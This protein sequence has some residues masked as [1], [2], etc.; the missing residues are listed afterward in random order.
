MDEFDL[1]RLD[2]HD[3]EVLCK[4]LFEDILGVPLEVFAQGRDGGVDLRHVAED[5]NTTV[6]QCKHWMRSGRGK[7]LSHM[8]N[9]ELPKIV[10]LSPDRY[11][12]A[13]SV[14]LTVAAKDTL[15]TDLAPYVRSTGDIYGIEQLV[16]ELR[17]RP[18]IVRRHYKLWLS[19][20]AVL[21]GV[22][23]QDV[24][25]RSA[26]LVEEV[27]D[28]VPT[29]VATSAFD[30]AREILAANSVCL[31]VGIP[32]IGK[33][34][35][36]R[37]LVKM[38]LDQG[39]QPI[40]LSDGLDE[41]DDMWLPDVPQ[42]FYYDD[43]LGRVALEPKLGKN[44]DGR[45]L[46][47][48]RRIRRTRGKR[49]ILTTREYILAQGRQRYGRLNDGDLDLSTCTI[50][51]EGFTAEVRAHIL[52]NHVRHSGIPITEKQRF[53]SSE[54]WSEIVRHPNFNPRLIT[55]TLR[56]ASR[57]NRTS[58]NVA[59]ELIRNLRN[60]EEIW[61]HVITEELDDAAVQLLEVMF[62]FG[63]ETRMDEVRRAWGRY[64]STLGE[65]DDQRLFLRALKTLN[66]S[67]ITIRRYDSPGAVED[68]RSDLV[69]S[70][71]RELD[72]H[73]PSIRDHLAVRAA[74]GLMSLSPLIESIEYREQILHLA[75]LADGHP[76]PGMAARFREHAPAATRAAI[77][78]YQD[79]A[80]SPS[81]EDESWA[82]NLEDTLMIADAF[83]S[84]ELAAFVVKRLDE[85]QSELWGSHAT[86]LV[87]LAE[88]VEESDLIPD[89][90]SHRLV[91]RMFDA[92]LSDSSYCGGDEWPR[93][94]HLAEVLSGLTVTGA[95]E[96]MQH[97][98]REMTTCVLDRL[99][100]WRT[101][102]GRREAREELERWGADGLDE[103]L[104]FL[105]PSA[106]PED[107]VE[108][109][110]AARSALDGDADEER[111]TSVPQLPSRSREQSTES[112][113][114]VERL[115]NL[116]AE[117]GDET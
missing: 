33:T 93:L 104:A 20:T 51:P 103:M 75:S 4:D 46:D 111:D 52:Y 100:Q 34:T 7:L 45:L 56:L 108:A 76:A 44:E 59:D 81:D 27:E 102:D 82:S 113:D 88:R 39:Y 117:E 77:K 28:C 40:A 16:A 114:A 91:A 17:K 19:G 60:P 55:Q 9:E 24:L 10:S 110:V 53:A 8:K 38:S 99:E 14:E 89:A 57:G 71:A 47:V 50:Q 106:V 84:V 29:F 112:A 42:V 107:L 64:R 109:Y 26:D 5:G 13:T 86:H 61:D 6:I 65:K 74:R 72:F 31:L 62:T 21:Q 32:G 2:A 63:Y 67:M 80:T 66:G 79:V 35:S 41:L 101:E 37:M 49:L 1:G 22:L 85:G 54:K 97:L 11:L 18:E 116:L 92:M 48:I 3:F 90:D 12:L 69:I 105:P 68:E 30:R 73:N 25:L 94:A 70:R 98:H 23:H 87:S 15:K 36:A 43:F 96:R 78:T 83:G 58:E 115:R 95:P